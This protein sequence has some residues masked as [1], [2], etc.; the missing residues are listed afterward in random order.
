MTRKRS[1]RLPLRV[2]RYEGQPVVVLAV[3]ETHIEEWC[4]DLCLLGRRLIEALV[5]LD[6]K[7][8][9]G[10]EIRADPAVPAEKVGHATWRSE[11][12]YVVV[13]LEEVGTWADFYLKYYRDGI[14]VVDHIDVDLDGTEQSRGLFLVL[15]VPLAEAPLP[16][17]KLRQHLRLA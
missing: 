2:S 7:S 3:D 16:G 8:E 4:L 15:K 1:W 12:A 17:D 10:L 11:R 5:V 13:S 14:G 6:P 9:V